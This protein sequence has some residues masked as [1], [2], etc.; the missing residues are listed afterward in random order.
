[1]DFES[2]ERFG[3]LGLG[4]GFDFSESY[5]CGGKIEGADI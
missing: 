2:W 1:M 4:N 5:L 3:E